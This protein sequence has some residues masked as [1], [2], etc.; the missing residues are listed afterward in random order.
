MQCK[1]SRVSA[2]SWSAL[3]EETS[4]SGSVDLTVVASA[5]PPDT[6][7]TGPS[8]SR[9]ERDDADVHGV[10]QDGGDTL[11]NIINKDIVTPEI[12]ESLLGAEHLGQAKLNMFVDK[13]LCEPPDSDQHLNLKSA[14]VN[15]Q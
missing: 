15:I 7:T 13:R 12:Q 10:F 14:Q 3:R 11:R 4:R 1:I 6:T 2:S 5:N 9:M 8:K